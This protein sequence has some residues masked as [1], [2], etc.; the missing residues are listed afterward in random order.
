MSFRS[1]TITVIG[2]CL[3][4]FHKLFAHA[5]DLEAGVV[6]PQ[7]IC[8]NDSTH[9]YALYLPSYYYTSGEESWPVIYAFDAAGRG[10]VPVELLSAAAEKYGYIV[11]GSN[12]SE[13]GPWEPILKAAEMM[14]KDTEARL[15]IDPSRRYTAGFSGGARVATSLAVLY[16]TFEGVI[17]CGAGFSR[18]YP[19]HFDLRFSY[20][21]LIGNRDFNYQEMIALDERLSQFRVDHYIEEFDGNHEWP[22]EAVLSDAVQWLHF[23][24]MK[25]ELIWIDYGMREDFYEIQE[26][27][28]R[29]FMNNDSFYDAYLTCKKTLSY[30]DGI[31]NLNDIKAIHDVLWRNPEVQ[32]QIRNRNRV[33]DE[34]RAFYRSYQSAFEDYRRNFE[35]SMTPVKPL[36]WWRE[37]LKTAN[38]FIERGPSPFDTLMGW[39]M[40]DFMWRSAYMNYEN[41]LGTDFSNTA[42]YYLD[43]WAQ[44][45]PDAISPYFFLAG[46]YA[47]GQKFSKAMEALN[48]AVRN[49]L[50]DAALIGADPSLAL[51]KGFPE[52]DRL[53][54]RLSPP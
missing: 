40:I 37:Q 22:P 2:L 53:L 50:E 3:V 29:L 49:G 34:E 17:G 45:Q 27:L 12:V 38:R 11:A 10:V 31:R 43:I 32:R 15:H 8:M 4:I 26:K 48:K 7:V 6:I 28:I 54:A 24:A 30:L 18:N 21:G 16:G 13:N 20:I 41:V 47:R 36:K 33:L 52:F 19:A 23:K 44:V 51:M 39:R 1:R 5:P 14:F 35:D 25:N 42:A 46:H 9:R